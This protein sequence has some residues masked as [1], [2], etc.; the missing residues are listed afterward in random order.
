MP[1][2]LYCGAELRIRTEEIRILN[3]WIAWGRC[4]SC[5]LSTG[6]KIGGKE[7]TARENLM[8]YLEGKEA[9]DA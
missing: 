5:G 4:D 3:C 8:P 6:C 1:R 9:K 7:E 2:C